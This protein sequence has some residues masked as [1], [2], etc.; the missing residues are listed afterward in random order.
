MVTIHWLCEK[1]LIYLRSW[2]KINEL[3][4]KT[5]VL[6]VDMASKEN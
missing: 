5:F 4:T 1:P 6:V 3:K 2:L